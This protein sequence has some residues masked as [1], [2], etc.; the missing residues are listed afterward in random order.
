M[1]M[2]KPELLSP[3]G[4]MDSLV[5]AIEGGCDAVYL[6]GTM[7][8]ARSFAANF[9]NE[10][11]EE[12]ITYAHLYGVKIY[13][14]INT[15]IYEAEV[16]N[17]LSYVDYLVSIH[18]DA[19]IVQDIG[20]MD[21]LR[22]LYP[23]LEIHASTQMHIHNLEGA[24][25]LESLGIKRVVL[26][27][28]TPIELVSEIRKE[29]SIELE[30][31]VHGALCISYSG[32]CLMSSLIGGRSGNR[33]TCAQCCRQPY[34]L[35]SNGKKINKDDYL[36]SAKDLNTLEYLPQL[37]ELGVDSLKIEGRMKRPEYVYFVTSLYRKAIDTYVETGKI[38]ITNQELETLKK[39][40]H[41]GFTKGF[42]FHEENNQFVNEYRPNHMGIPIGVVKSRKGNFLEIELTKEL[43]IGDGI[44]IL[45]EKEDFG[46]EIDVIWKGKEKVKRGYPKEIVRI[47]FKENVKEGSL[48]VKTTD[49][50][51]LDTI[52]KYIT[53]KS[54]KVP[55]KFFLEVKKNLPMKLKIE[56]GVR[57]C[58][59]VSD[60]LVEE[61][62][63]S[64][65][66]KERILSQLEK[67]GGT[68]YCLDSASLDCDD[69]IFI[70]IQKI[71]E[72]RRIG[73]EAITEKRLE[74]KIL[75]KGT[76]Q[77]DLPNFPTKKE[78]SVYV[79]TLE[80]YEKIKNKGYDE[81]YMNKEVLEMV[82]NSKFTLKIPRV[83]EHLKENYENVLV[84]ELGSVYHYPNAV[85]DFSLNVVNSYSVAFLHSLGIRKVTLSYELND[86]Q[87][88]RLI[89]AYHERYQKHPCLELIVLGK[90]EAMIMKYNFLKKYSIENK[91]NILI[92]K[93]HNQFPVRVKDNYLY[94][95]HYQKRKLEDTDK[96]YEMGITSLRDSF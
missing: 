94:I 45:G 26:A 13:V 53:S 65:I 32:Q 7:Y 19:V 1:F 63:N 6:S 3:A 72:L 9:T 38:E 47:P 61:S 74:R 57:T 79:T 10:Q 77:K 75:K 82:K 44:R 62:K 90:I 50:E 83:Q 84:G 46:K 5:A 78:K 20:M 2:K 56:D 91:E 93:Y 76:Y 35:S 81:I 64:P 66:T 36:L 88:E 42:L 67:L 11:L 48:L 4:N 89:D 29:T 95:Y 18:V 73:I 37:I 52:Q 69:F 34:V 43:N 55:L 12:A 17:F 21:L 40:F 86:Y 92:D 28:E 51:D 54:R 27:R 23:E 31:F 70:P 30:I 39:I 16:K 71:N 87:I 14:T 59:V 58:E 25:L 22:G 24:K 60:F 8:G 85:S 15:L 68:V 96:Y 41:R 33:G 80:E 49:R